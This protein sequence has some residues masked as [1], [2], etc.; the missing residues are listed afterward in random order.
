[1]NKRT[2]I[3]AAVLLAI[4]ATIGVVFAFKQ[5][6]EPGKA[7][8][9]TQA[10][11]R[12]KHNFFD[13]DFAKQMI[14]DH[15]QAIEM[16]DM[17]MANSANSEVRQL[18][19]NIKAAREPDITKMKNWLTGWGEQYNDLSEFPQMSGHDMYPTLPGMAAPEDLQKLK[20]MTGAEFDRSFLQIMLDHHKGA[21]E[22]A[23]TQ[24]KA[25]QYGE[26]IGLA[27][28]IEAKQLNEIKKINDLQVK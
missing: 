6:S 11:D 21:A 28:S 25:G 13:V 12:S 7:P 8:A 3:V 24:Q 20:A 23:K 18:A 14:I 2:V 17:A 26:I 1:M 10:V 9:Q 19:A 5:K 16:S 15:Q 27:K 4:A 22:M